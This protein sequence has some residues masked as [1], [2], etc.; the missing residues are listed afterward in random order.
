M[1]IFNGMAGVGNLAHGATPDLTPQD[2]EF[3]DAVGIWSHCAAEET[4]LGVGNKRASVRYVPRNIIGRAILTIASRRIFSYA[5]ADRP[6][7]AWLR[8]AL[9]DTG[10]YLLDIGV[11]TGDLAAHFM[12][13]GKHVHGVDIAETYI[14]H[15]LK[16]EIIEHGA[17][18]NIETELPPTPRTFDPRLPE[19]YDVVFLGEILEHLLSAREAIRKAADVCRPGGAIIITTPNLAYLGNRIRLLLG[20]DLHPLTIDRGDVGHQHIRV[21]TARLL[22]QLLRQANCRVINVASD[23]VPI[24]LGRF[25]RVEYEGANQFEATPPPAQLVMPLSGGLFPTF[26]RTIFVEAI[27]QS[28]AG[29][30]R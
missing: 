17:V 2:D 1:A 11:R 23:G 21:F 29:T 10:P 13:W 8:R 9:K 20:R 27:R 19:R 5:E 26:G 25:V 22:E 18:C 3:R 14:E 12:Q 24:A 4:R 15:C 16:K 30:G 28:D 6:K 7:L